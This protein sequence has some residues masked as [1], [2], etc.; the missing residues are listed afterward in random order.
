MEIRCVEMFV[1]FG[2]YPWHVVGSIVDLIGDMLG[3]DYTSEVFYRCLNID[4]LSN[5]FTGCYSITCQVV[6]LFSLNIGFSI[7]SFYDLNVS[8]LGFEF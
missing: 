2:D 5:L 8:L 1:A 6:I 7:I 4:G 3:R